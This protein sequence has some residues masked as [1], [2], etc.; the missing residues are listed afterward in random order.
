VSGECSVKSGEH[1]IGTIGVPVRSGECSISSKKHP[2][3]SIGIPCVFFAHSIRCKAHP[4]S[5]GESPFGF[6]EYPIRPIGLSVKKIGMLFGML[7]CTSM[8]LKSMVT[9]MPLKETGV[10]FKG[11][12]ILDK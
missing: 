2:I 9:T 4:S 3:V 6:G 12:M 10:S 8:T 11:S 5:F 1:P 7:A